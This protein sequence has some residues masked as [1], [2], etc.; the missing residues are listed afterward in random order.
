MIA[1]EKDLTNT[2]SDKGIF[3][4]IRE[5]VSK[6]IKTLHKILKENTPILHNKNIPDEYRENFE[7][8]A[9]AL[10]EKAWDIWTDIIFDD[11]E[12]ESEEAKLFKKY[13]SD[14]CIKGLS[15]KIKN[16]FY[17][18]FYIAYTNLYAD[19]AFP[20]EVKNAAKKAGASGELKRLQEAY[21][22][23]NYWSSGLKKWC[24]IYFKKKED[25]IINTLEYR[26]GYMVRP[27]IYTAKDW[28]V[29]EK[30]E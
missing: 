20:W 2:A 12:K 4:N 13:L 21:G 11:K 28:T 14:E 23:W 25:K 15:K 10:I 27:I 18:T 1:I 16:T 30:K 9:K 26:P 19:H 5:T 6:G 8:N 7:I 24:S 29:E 3:K 22:M 17:N